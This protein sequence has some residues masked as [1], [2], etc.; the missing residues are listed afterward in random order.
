MLSSD[1]HLKGIMAPESDISNE[2]GLYEDGELNMFARTERLLLR[3]SWPE[4]A[5]HLHNAIADHDIVRNLAL[6]PWPYN[7]DD[8][9]SFIAAPQSITHPNFFLF[10]RTDG[11][12]QLIGGCGLSDSTG[13]SE[14]GYWIARPYWGLGYASEA[15]RAVVDI[16]RAIGHRNLV[17]G[18]FTDNPAS[19]RVL[20]KAGFRS[21]GRVAMRHSKGRGHAVPCAMFELSLEDDEGGA[22]G[23]PDFRDILIPYD[24][25]LIAA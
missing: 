22:M 11:A 16:A 25:Q 5:E 9:R 4:D 19:R 24:A 18:H 3:P 21:T 7:L 20:E 8:A 23:E 1:C 14:I 17:A 15:A 12:P 2:D 6:A 10:R 13:E